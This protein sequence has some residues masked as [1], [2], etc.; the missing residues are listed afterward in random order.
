MHRLH[1]EDQDIACHEIVG[2]PLT[3]HGPDISWIFGKP[4]SAIQIHSLSI[5]FGIGFLEDRGQ[6]RTLS[7]E[8][9][10]LEGSKGHLLCPAVTGG[11]THRELSHK[12]RGDKGLNDRVMVSPTHLKPFESREAM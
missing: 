9:Y 6:H 1:G 3:T 11:S 12:A 8:K 10:K 4:A 2:L 7:S 5:H